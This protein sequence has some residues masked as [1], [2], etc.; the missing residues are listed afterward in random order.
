[1]QPNSS[2][3]LRFHRHGADRFFERASHSL[4]QSVGAD[5]FFFF[6]VVVAIHRLDASF[7]FIGM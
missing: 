7:V 6:F 3:L 2:S 5:G 4:W 1:M